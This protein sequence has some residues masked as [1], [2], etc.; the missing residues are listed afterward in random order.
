MTTPIDVMEPDDLT[1][2][3][4]AVDADL[5]F[6]SL[7]ERFGGWWSA[8][9]KRFDEDPGKIVEAAVSFVAVAL[10]TILVFAVL[11]PN[12]FLNDKTPTGGDMGSHLWGPRYLLDHLLPHFRLSGWTPDWYD[13]F[14]AYQFYMVIP[15]LL[16]V[17]IYVGLPWY[18]AIP[19]LI[20]CVALGLLGWMKERLYRYR[21]AL[22]GIAG[23]LAVWVIPLSY[24]RSFKLVT[25]LGLLGL[26]AA[27]WLFAKLS[28]LPFPAPP[29][30][31]AA[32]LI[33]IFNRQPTFN[34]T[35]N[36]I[37]GNFQSTMAGEFAFSISLTFAVLYLG[38]AVRGLRTGKHR[39]LAAV[40]FAAAGLCHVIP[41][42]FVLA[43]TA[44]L[45]V[46]HP[47]KARF[48][49]LLTMVPVAG[50]L[51]AFW[52]VPFYLRSDYVNDMGWEKLP[53]P[54]AEQNSISYYLWPK[55]LLWLFV[56]A[57]V[58]VVVSVLR[59]RS[60]GMVLAIAW[61]GVALGFVFLPQAR[62]WNARL[63][64]FMYLSVALLA[65]IGLAE[66]IHLA[67]TAAAGDA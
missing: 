57:A 17:L 55:A 40:L 4:E 45:F 24:N 33:F 18:L 48:K 38:V 61:A 67:A 7:G 8:T 36:I 27:C 5:R 54:N 64:P 51:T 31:A 2:P 56:M 46:V 52:V 41:A 1:D 58:G 25:G 42:F 13:G 60:I 37:G 47:D 20:G 49:W 50:L 21:L 6:P 35:G 62:L 66:L 32:A 30:A 22:V 14:P 44:A 19:A 43:C 10:A 63:L 34:D 53:V 26:P 3:P 16:V 15:S 11:R 39:A 65:A 59:K 29:L 28:D 23:L 12:Q 9:A